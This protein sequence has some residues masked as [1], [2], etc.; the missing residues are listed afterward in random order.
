[1]CT[2]CFAFGPLD[3]SG[4]D[5]VHQF[6]AGQEMERSECLPIVLR[7]RANFL[8]AASG[9]FSK[10][11]SGEF[12]LEMSLLRDFFHCLGPLSLIAR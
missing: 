8:P 7:S 1:M 4:R 6:T 5:C 10:I 11:R 9:R 12:G 3:D 2:C